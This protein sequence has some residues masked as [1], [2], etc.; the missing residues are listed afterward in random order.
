[1]NQDMID[2]IKGEASFL[3][4]NWLGYWDGDNEVPVDEREA[5]S[6]YTEDWRRS[7]AL[8]DPANSVAE[9]LFGAETTDLLVSTL[10]GRDRVL[11]RAMGK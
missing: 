10:W 7:I 1:M 9:A 11:P 4:D 3:L 2:L 8:G 5:M 6:K